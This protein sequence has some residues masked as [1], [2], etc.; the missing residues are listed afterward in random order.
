MRLLTLFVVLVFESVDIILLIWLIALCYDDLL[1][2]GVSLIHVFEFYGFIRL[3]RVCHFDL[4]EA[5]FCQ[6]LFLNFCCMLRAFDS[7][8]CVQECLYEL[9]GS[10][11]AETELCS[12]VDGLL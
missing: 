12:L 3:V 5:I 7:F 11:V 9:A 2:A 1:K 10:P 8:K 4:T 6:N